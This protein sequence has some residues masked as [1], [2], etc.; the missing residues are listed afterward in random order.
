[1]HFF[2]SPALVYE[3]QFQPDQSAYPSKFVLKSCSGAGEEMHGH[4]AG[5]MIQVD[6]R[7]ENWNE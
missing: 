4:T 7:N 1:M 5:I 6:R 2:S 3:T